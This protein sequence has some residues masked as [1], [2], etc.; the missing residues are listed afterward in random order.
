MQFAFPALTRFAAAALVAFPLAIVLTNSGSAQQTKDAW[1]GRTV[2]WTDEAEIKIGSRT[3]P[4]SVLHATVE[5]VRG[6]WL[7]VASGWL[8]KSDALTAK[9][10]FAYYS[11][12]LQKNRLD[13]EVWRYRGGVRAWMKDID[14]AIADYSESIRL[15][16][17]SVEA[18]MAR[19][20]VWQLKGDPKRAM[21]DWTEAVRLSPADGRVLHTRGVEWMERGDFDRAIEDFSKVLELEPDAGYAHYS[22]GRARAANGEWESAIE[23]FT[24][25]IALEPNLALAYCDRAI[26]FRGRGDFALAAADF[27]RAIEADPESPRP[28]RCS[29]WLRATCPNVDCRDGRRAVSDAAKA[30]E[31]TRWKNSYDLD[32]LAASYAEAGNFDAAVKWQQKAIDLKP[33][34]AKFV[35]SA[36]TRLELYKN[37]KPYRER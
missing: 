35:K 21:Q 11:A 15:A 19:G 13:S 5:A 6:D 30:C 36:K 27:N 24:A 26:A 18:Y 10:A 9:Q 29:A 14:G 16:P 28:Y 7:W 3:V 12:R 25:A 32:T 2:F 8:R 20:F 34:D 31:L 23:D 33:D 1:V 17:A 22:R 4:R 37:H